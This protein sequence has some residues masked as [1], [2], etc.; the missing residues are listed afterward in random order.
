M[1]GPP[2]AAVQHVPV[3]WSKGGF[4]Q[5]TWICLHRECVSACPHACAHAHT[6]T[7][8]VRWVNDA[9]DWMKCTDGVRGSNRMR[10]TAQTRLMVKNGWFS[11]AVWWN[12]MSATTTWKSWRFW[13][14]QGPSSTSSWWTVF[15]CVVKGWRKKKN[16]TKCVNNTKVLAVTWFNL[17]KEF[18]NVEKRVV[19]KADKL[20]RCLPC[21]AD[22]IYKVN[23]AEEKNPQKSHQEGTYIETA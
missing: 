14:S 7:Q 22:A 21:V 17:V 6:H 18:L 8:G 3:K 15:H 13:L 16:F 11:N 19:F 2:V 12:S 5:R 1:K 9:T 10:V 23:G 20:E 4:S